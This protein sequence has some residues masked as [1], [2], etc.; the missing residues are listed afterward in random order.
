M[1]AQALRTPIA[2]VFA[3]ILALASTAS[4][5]P[6]IDRPG[7]QVALH[8]ADRPVPGDVVVVEATGL[9]DVDH[10]VRVE[11]PDGSETVT[12]V[13]PAGGRLV[14]EFTLRQ[15]GRH[16]VWLEGPDLEARFTLTSGA[17][18]APG[19]GPAREAVPTPA[20]I[21]P[22]TPAPTP[23]PTPPTATD[24]PTLA[25]EDN[26]V[27]A[28]E[29]DGTVRWRLA[30]PTDSGTTRLA[31]LHLDRVW[32]AHGHQVLTLDP[33][34]GR[35]HRR[36]PTSG[37][38]VELH[39][40][41]TGLAVFSEVHAPGAP[42][43]VEARLADGVL[44]P[45]ALFDP[46]SDLFDAL[47]REARVGDPSARLAIDPT[48]PFLRLFAAD[49]APTE[50]ERDAETAS[51]IAAATTFFDL[52]RLAREFADRGWWEAADAAMAAA[53]ADFAARGYDPALLT[54]PVIH[55]R[56]GFP[57]RPLQRAVM[58]DDP[59]SAALWARWL[60]EL[61]GPDLPGVGAELRAF[62]AALTAAGDREGAAAW[63]ERAS[64]RTNPAVSEAL[65]KAAL[66]LGRGGILASAAL[67]IALLMLH[68]TLVAKYRRAQE[69]AS[70]QAREAGRRPLPWPALRAIRYYGLTEKAAL[71]IV[72]A[73]A[74]AAVALVGWVERGDALAAAAAAGHLEAPTAV[75][76]WSGA[77]GDPASLA[78]VEAYR[79]ERTGRPDAAREALASA[80]GTEVERALAAL[81]QGAPVPTPSPATLRAA[82][83]GS[84][85]TAVADAFVRPQSLLDDHL[86][87][88]GLPAWS[89]PAQL[90]LFWLVALWH[91]GW[92]L[93]PRPR[94]AADAP[95][96]LAYHLLALAVPGSGQADELYGVL[97]IV[98]WALFGID[99]LS[100]LLGSASPLGIPFS[101]GT[102]VLSTLYLVNAVAWAVEY[103]SVR[104]RLAV[105]KATQPELARAFGLTPSRSA[106]AAK[107]HG[108]A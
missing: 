73:A 9:R 31:L 82:A 99:A 95:R 33:A 56:Y 2:L 74:Y 4:A 96:P 23:E 104:K 14:V 61:S 67:L 5:Q 55:E 20:P 29:A 25:V 77:R 46:A 65:A 78:M 36:V 39:P 26:T 59:A 79:A 66:A 41:G 84:W 1:T 13:A 100:Q 43:R 98:P 28:L 90:V 50:T 62:G 49:A 75:A 101:A 80:T 30:F 52:A 11:A 60:F 94:Y 40:V 83:G 107:D 6:A 72:L 24:A 64:E 103:A 45:P 18:P 85:T 22:A 102:V 3:L 42:L 93:V 81:A 92:L 86:E 38:V 97:L 19:A 21:P 76:L 34:D 106:E 10:A 54:S 35:V 91:L 37:A 88:V 87:L 57:L 105:L 71:L 12:V 15:M 108:R 16:V 51:A 89:W 44:T 69:L 17:P 47:Q 7:P 8:V 27:V 53:A 63:R 58:R 32:V 68:L 70:R 48:N